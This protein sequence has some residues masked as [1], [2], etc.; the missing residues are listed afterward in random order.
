MLFENTS[1]WQM[2]VWAVLLWMPQNA[3]HEY[4]HGLMAKHWKYTIDKVR[5]YPDLIDADKDGKVDRVYFAWVET[6]KS[7]DREANPTELG[8]IDIAPQLVNTLV[9]TVLFMV[10]F[11]F[12]PEMPLWAASFVA[13]LALHNWIDGSFNML[14]IFRKQGSNDTWRYMRRW[15]I[16]LLPLRNAVLSWSVFWGSALFWGFWHHL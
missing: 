3:I 4:S 13:V 9:L 5:L 10:R 12:W 6:G 11:V 2:L 14:S 1:W 7:E 16:P 8:S 15:E